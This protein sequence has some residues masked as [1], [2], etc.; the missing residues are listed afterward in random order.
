MQSPL[1]TPAKNGYLLFAD[2]NDNEPV[3][4]D[5]TRGVPK[6]IGFTRKKPP[7]WFEWVPIRIRAM[8]AANI[9][10]L[11]AGV[12]DVV[13]RVDPMA[14]FDGRSGGVLR[15]VSKTDGKKLAEYKLDSPPVFDGM[16]AAAGRLY[17]S[18]RDGKV[19][20]MAE[21]GA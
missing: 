12:P 16:A 4:P 2:A 11:V 14:A 21:S 5:Y 8:V 3:L 15:V 7:V 10:L 19:T 13:E 17:L 1:F 9:A 20:C 18:T 6:G